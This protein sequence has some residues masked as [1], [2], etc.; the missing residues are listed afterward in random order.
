M[1]RP[2]CTVLCDFLA[3]PGVKG[4]SAT[5]KR[6][7]RMMLSVRSVGVRDSGK[8]FRPGFMREG[9][10]VAGHGHVKQLRFTRRPGLG[11]SEHAKGLTLRWVENGNWKW[12]EI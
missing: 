7:V 12:K 4:R 11:G 10:G 5:P 9:S 6:E 1:A 2:P 3:R 8:G